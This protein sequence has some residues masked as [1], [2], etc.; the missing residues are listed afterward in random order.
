MQILAKNGYTILCRIAARLRVDELTLHFTAA[1]PDPAAAAA[2]YAA[3]A[4]AMDALSQLGGERLANADLR[5]D[6][7][8]DAD[9]PEL[10][11]YIR[12]S[13][14]VY[15]LLAAAAVFGFGFLRDYIRYKKGK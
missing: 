12:L 9:E 2:A 13:I 15:R 1:S 4:L 6:V 5:A 7:D 14:R 8:F 10:L 3:A 11:L